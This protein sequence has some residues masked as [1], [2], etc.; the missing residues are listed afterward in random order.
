MKMTIHM[1][2]VGL[3][4]Q[5]MKMA[6]HMIMI[7]FIFKMRIELHMELNLFVNYLCRAGT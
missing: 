2:M 5:K 1:I 6:I 4:V 7:F 3:R